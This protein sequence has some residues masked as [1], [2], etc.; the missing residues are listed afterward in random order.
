V[1]QVV[2]FLL[3]EEIFLNSLCLDRRCLIHSR[4][5]SR[6]SPVLHQSRTRGRYHTRDRLL[7]VVSVSLSV[8]FVRET[9]R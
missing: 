5:F 7:F 9:D 8:V 4:L 1:T 3:Y 6:R 2:F